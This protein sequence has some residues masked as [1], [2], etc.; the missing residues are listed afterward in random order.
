MSS[1][2]DSLPF[3]LTAFTGEE[4]ARE[5]SDGWSETAQLQIAS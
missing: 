3:T 1:L 5:A 2:W 4:E